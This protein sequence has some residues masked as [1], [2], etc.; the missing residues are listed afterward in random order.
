M[1]EYNSDA[2]SAAHQRFL[3]D[4]KSLTDDDLAQFAVVD[5]KL[6]ERARAKRAGFV[7]AA[8]DGAATPRQFAKSITVKV[9]LDYQRD[10]LA[11]ILATHKYRVKQLTETVERL[12]AHCRSLEQRLL[13]LEVDRAVSH[14]G[15]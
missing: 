7:E 11:P 3:T 6:A 2:F 1:A 12:D 15:R 13:E 5:P 4:A 8:E 9:L 10:C 14:A